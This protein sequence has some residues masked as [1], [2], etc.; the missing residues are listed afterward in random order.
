MFKVEIVK[1]SA[2]SSL[3][4]FK[5]EIKDMDIQENNLYSHTHSLTHTHILYTS[6]LLDESEAPY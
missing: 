3:A 2:I 4:S 6:V 1:K 5:K